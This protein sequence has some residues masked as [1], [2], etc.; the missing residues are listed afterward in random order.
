[1]LAATLAR[2]PVTCGNL[3]GPWLTFQEV[4]RQSNNSSGTEGGAMLLKTVR[5]VSAIT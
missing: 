4:V 1:M 2:A 5:D 3:P